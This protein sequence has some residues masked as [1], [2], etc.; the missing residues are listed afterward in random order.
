MT[1][2]K[3]ARFLDSL[4][5]APVRGPV[6]PSTP[7]TE[8]APRSRLKEDQRE[9][10]ARMRTDN[11]SSPSTFAASEY[12]QEINERFDTLLRDEGI[13]D[14]SRQGFNALFSSPDRTSGKYHHYAVYLLY[15]AV[16]AKDT[17]GL[18]DRIQ[19]TGGG[20]VSYSFGEHRVSWDLLISLDTLYALGELDSAVFDQPV[21]VADLGSGWGRIGHVLKQ[22][23]PHAAYIALDL[24]E[25]LL[26]ASTYLPR[27][28][29]SER[30]FGYD[31]NRDR[32]FTRDELLHRTGLSFMGPRTWSGSRT[33]QSTSSS[34]SRAS[35]R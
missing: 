5:L 8:D 15:R 7:I 17:R 25:S 14:V 10:L 4:R 33:A 26:V 9:L 28:L 13:K 23:N 24:P 34:T 21:V 27:T 30:V 11:A 2:A 6:E 31:E 16:R 3:L 19:S 22:V 1:P 18:L 29:P 32:D 12:W 20:K 35:R